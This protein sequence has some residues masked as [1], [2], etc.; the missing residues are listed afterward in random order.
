MSEQA[1]AYISEMDM[2]KWSIAFG[3]GHRYGYATTNMAEVFNGIMKG[4]RFLPVAA[5]VEL[6]FYRV[7][8]WFVRKGK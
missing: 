2:E 4:A 8:K 5:I 1:F 3:G 6:T 7:N